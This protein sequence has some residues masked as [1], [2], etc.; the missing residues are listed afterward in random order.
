MTRLSGIFVFSILF[1]LGSANATPQGPARDLDTL[2]M[3]EAKLA[4]IRAALPKV[5][6]PNLTTILQSTQTIWY[7]ETT[8]KRSY[9]DSVGAS[10][11]DKWP[12]LVA[13]SES[14]IGGLHNRANHKWQ[15][16]FA[17]T[18]GTDDSTNLRVANFVSLP[19]TNGQVQTMAISKVYLNDNRPEWRWKD[20][21]G[22]VFGEVLFIV[23][24][25]RLLPSEIRTRTRYAAGWAMNVYRP[26]PRAIDLS[27]AIKRLRPQWNSQPSLSAMIDFL[28]DNTTLKPARL[29]AK[30]ALA[31][32]FQQDGYI[33]ELPDFEDDALV[34]ELLTTTPFVSAYDTSWKSNG[35]QET[36]AA[37][38]KSKLSVVPN[39]YMGGLIRVTDDSC[40]RCHKDTNRLV[41]E[42]Y[43]ALY[44]YGELWGMD[45]IFTF[46]P[47]DEKHYPELRFNMIDNRYINP[48][49]KQAG[50]FRAAFLK[51]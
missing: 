40:M 23:D 3:P 41:S 35:A 38:T 18:A 36:Y 21:A 6:N 20:P 19:Q 32:T 7:D 2:I 48:K 46:H 1:A 45:G 42:F 9:Q 28:N 4:T 24:G 37:S 15:F 10:S 11:N 17:G 30:A 44:L 34:R 43:G 14:I 27:D 13:A 39:H 50:I 49:L 29:A 26:F 5:G 8:M 51:D 16:P 47:Y 22:T 33:D 12:D 31:P 25:G